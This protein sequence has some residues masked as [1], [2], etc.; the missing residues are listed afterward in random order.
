MAQFVQIANF[1]PEATPVF[2]YVDDEISREGTRGTWARQKKKFESGL[3]M[4][5]H[6]LLLVPCTALARI[7]AFFRGPVI[8]RAGPASQ[9]VTVPCSEFFGIALRE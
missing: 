3:C 8:P 1:A 6:Q 7:F 4:F 5:V 2:E 9:G